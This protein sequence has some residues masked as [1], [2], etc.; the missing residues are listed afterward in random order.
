MTRRRRTWLAPLQSTSRSI[1]EVFGA[2]R[3]QRLKSYWPALAVL[4]VLAIILS[5]LTAMSPI[6]PFVYPLF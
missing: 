5:V 4:V 6:A 2:M 3:R 1:G